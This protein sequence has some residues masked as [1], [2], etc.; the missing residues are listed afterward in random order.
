L[1]ADAPNCPLPKRG[2]ITLPS[3]KNRL[4]IEIVKPVL[5]NT[6]LVGGLTKK[7]AKKPKKDQKRVDGTGEPWYN[8][9][10]DKDC[11]SRGGDKND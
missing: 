7:V 9:D 1:D 5:A 2:I 11:K 8:V 3:Q 6:S 10:K 4:K